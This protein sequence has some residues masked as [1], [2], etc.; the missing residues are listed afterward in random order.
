MTDIIYYFGRFTAA[1]IF[2]VLNFYSIYLSKKL[3]K[4]SWF[5]WLIIVFIFCFMFLP[6][7]FGLILP[8]IFLVKYKKNKEKVLS[9]H[10]K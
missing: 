5:V 4:T 3:K 1:M 9:S 10:S 7:I 2:Y 6:T 8:I